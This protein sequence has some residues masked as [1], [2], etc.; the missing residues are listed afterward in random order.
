MAIMTRTAIIKSLFALFCVFALLS[1][2]GCVEREV[3]TPAGAAVIVQRAPPEPLVEVQSSPPGP[4]ELWVWQR[5]HWR[6]DGRDYR[7][8]AG[9]WAERPPHVTEWVA[10][11]WEPHPNGGYVFIEGGWR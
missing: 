4:G 7:W 10:P 9:R 3:V 5:G 8:M 2:T 11:R 6:W 1:T